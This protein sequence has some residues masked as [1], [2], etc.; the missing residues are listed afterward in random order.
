MVRFETGVGRLQEIIVALQSLVLSLCGDN[1]ERGGTTNIVFGDRYG[2]LRWMCFLATTDPLSHENCL[3][4]LRKNKKTN[5][6]DIFQNTL[7]M[8]SIYKIIYGYWNF[9]LF[10][11]S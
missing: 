5:K 7:Q 1:T 4:I 6:N 8:K 9:V 10:D 3:T 11:P 2:Q